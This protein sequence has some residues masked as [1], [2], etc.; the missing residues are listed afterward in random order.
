MYEIFYE[1]TSLNSM[2]LLLPPL[3]LW[4][5]WQSLFWLPLLKE[6]FQCI[7]IQRPPGSMEVIASV[8]PLHPACQRHQSQQA[9][10]QKF[11]SLFLSG[12]HISLLHFSHYSPSSVCNSLS[13][14]YYPW[15]HSTGRINIASKHKVISYVLVH[16][17]I[18]EKNISLG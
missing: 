2:K 4:I 8:P 3:L 7:E 13:N 16:T 11:L 17:K 15:R 18:T 12:C 6:E 1:K 10:L 5:Q 9:F 14:F